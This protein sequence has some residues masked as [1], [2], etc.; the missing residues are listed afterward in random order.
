MQTMPFRVHNLV[1]PGQFAL[2]KAF[3]ALGVMLWYHDIDNMDEYLVH[4]SCF[5][6]NWELCLL[7]Y[8]QSDL[9]ILIGNV[10]DAFGDIDPAKIIIKIKIHLLP[11]LVK[12]ISVTL[13]WPFR[14]LLRSLNVSMLYFTC[15]PS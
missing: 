6:G 2:V 13:V 8:I 4:S 9:E 7:V 11:H 5:Q 1:T 3:G 14:I 15:A 12:D 10:L